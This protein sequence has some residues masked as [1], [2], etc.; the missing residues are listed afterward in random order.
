[1]PREGGHPVNANSAVI[2]GSSAGACHPAALRAGPLADDDSNS[3][4]H[5]RMINDP[6]PIIGG[7]FVR[8][9][10]RIEIGE[11]LCRQRIGLA[12]DLAVSDQLFHPRDRSRDHVAEVLELL[13]V[14]ELAMA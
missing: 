9:P 5:H 8:C 7:L 6:D 10:F 4:P 2:T 11:R 12:L 14:G 3:L 13:L 1:M